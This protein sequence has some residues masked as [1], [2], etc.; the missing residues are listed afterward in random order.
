[1]STL[2]WPWD[3]NVS[4][5]KSTFYLCFSSRKRKVTWGVLN[6]HVWLNA[7]IGADVLDLAETMVAS[8]GLKYEPVSMSAS[9]VRQQFIY[10]IIKMYTHHH[11]HGVLSYAY[12]AHLSIVFGH[13]LGQLWALSAAKIVAHVRF[14][15]LTCI[16]LLT[17]ICEHSLKEFDGIFIQHSALFS[18]YL[19]YI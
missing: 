2:Q 1:M 16:T 11:A 15:F 10:C 17:S 12:N 4:T 6:L 3:A 5:K 19:H 14:K 18:S 8:D 7:D 13:V 9:S